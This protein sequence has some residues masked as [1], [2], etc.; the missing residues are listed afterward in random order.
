MRNIDLRGLYVLG[1]TG[2]QLKSDTDSGLIYHNSDALQF[3]EGSYS[4]GSGG[5][6]CTGLHKNVGVEIVGLLLVA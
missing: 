1:R 3:T 2:I 4:K 5:G 6:T